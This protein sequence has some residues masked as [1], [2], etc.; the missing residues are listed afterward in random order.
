MKLWRYLFFGWLL[1]LGVRQP[2]LAQIEQHM[3]SYDL[4]LDDCLA[5]TFR[6]YPE[7]Q[8]LRTDV[9]RAAGSRTIYRSRAL[10]QL[11]TQ[12]AVGLRGG[13]LYK[14]S[15]I[16]TNASTS[17]ITTNTSRELIPTAFST[18]AA[19][20]SQPL[21]DVGIPSSLRRGRLEVVIAQQSL[22][23]EVTERLHEARTTFLRA[24]YFRD[25]IALYADIDQRLLANVES[26]QH[27]LDVGTG[28][29]AALKSA[30][31]QELNL[32][33]QLSN[34]HGD[35]FTTVTR[36]AELCGLNLNEDTK[37]SRQLWLPRPVG[38]LL[39][40]PAKVDLPRE[41][42]YAL[43]HRADL[44]LLRAMVDATAADRQTVQAGYFPLVSLVGTALLIPE[45]YL[46]TKQTQIVA[47]QQTESTEGRAGVALSWQIIDNGQVTGQSRK[48]E[49]TRQIYQITLRKLEQNVP[50]ELATVEGSLQDADARRDALVKSV[51]E[52]EENLKLIETQIGL[53]Q[54]TQLDFLNA[55]SNLLSVRAGLEDA[56]YSHEIARAELDH[57]TGRYLQYHTDYVP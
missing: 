32:Q 16:E 1:T 30:K 22:N 56:T 3:Q 19:E 27:R 45:S 50:R 14:S 7:I 35:Y 10:P 17:A 8:R 40:E 33:L 48:I 25:L 4:T 34:L 54:A 47:G 13:D 38:E 11:S 42:A 18:V 43:Q 23:R 15:N 44:Q 46:L 12:I 9:E 6:Q 24:L 29:E 49:A 28:N 57:V 26:E 39:Y 2:A 5:S 52:A 37:G 36:I 51:A 20:F 31:I 53:G 55:Q 41:S 21:I